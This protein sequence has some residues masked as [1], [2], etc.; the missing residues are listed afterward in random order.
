MRYKNWDKQSL[1]EGKESRRQNGVVNDATR[2]TLFLW[3]SS[4]PSVSTR[5]R[6][7]W[8]QFPFGADISQALKKGCLLSNLH[9]LGQDGAID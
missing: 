5:L 7:G 4:W 3:L 9:Q 2:S 1:K 6:K 8:W